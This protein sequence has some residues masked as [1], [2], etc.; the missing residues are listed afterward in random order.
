MFNPELVEQ[1]S[2][3]QILIV[4]RKF[5]RNNVEIAPTGLY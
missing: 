2:K 3:F 4:H 5:Y 1:F